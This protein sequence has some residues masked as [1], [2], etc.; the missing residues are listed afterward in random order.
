MAVFFQS[1]SSTNGF[2]SLFEKK[3]DPNEQ[4][5]ELITL[6]G[7][8][9]R[10]RGIVCDVLKGKRIEVEAF[11]RRQKLYHAILNGMIQKKAV[12]ELPE[13]KEQLQTCSF[14]SNSPVQTHVKS[15]IR[16]TGFTL[17][18]IKRLSRY[19]GLSECLNWKSQQHAQGDLPTELY[20]VLT[21]PYSSETCPSEA[22]L[23]HLFSTAGL[24]T[25]NGPVFWGELI[26]EWKTLFPEVEEIGDAF[27]KKH[28][29]AQIILYKKGFLPT[30]PVTLPKGKELPRRLPLSKLRETCVFHHFVSLRTIEALEWTLGGPHFPDNIRHH[31][32]TTFTLHENVR[33]D[34]SFA[35]SFPERLL[36]NPLPSSGKVVEILAFLRTLLNFNLGH[37]PKDHRRDD[38]MQQLYSWVYETNEE[39]VRGLLSHEYPFALQ[40]F[41][42]KDG[43]PM[44]RPC[45]PQQLVQSVSSLRPLYASDEEFNENALALVATHLLLDRTEAAFEFVLKVNKHPC[46]RIHTKHI[47]DYI[48]EK[49]HLESFEE[50]EQFF[51]F[52]AENLPLNL[53]GPSEDFFVLLIKPYQTS[54]EERKK[55]VLDFLMLINGQGSIN[56]DHFFRALHLHLR[57][58][59]SPSIQQVFA[60]FEKT[61][62]P[63]LSPN[64]KLFLFLQK[65]SPSP[66]KICSQFIQTVVV[67][68]LQSLP[69]NFEKTHRL[70]LFYEL[71][72][73]QNR[74][75][76]LSQNILFIR[77]LE[78]F[79]GMKLSPEVAYQLLAAHP[80]LSKKNVE[81]MFQKLTE[82]RLRILN[83][84]L[85][86]VMIS[87]GVIEQVNETLGTLTSS[88]GMQDSYLSEG[89]SITQFVLSSAMLFSRSVHHTRCF[90][91]GVSADDT[92]EFPKTAAPHA[93]LPLHSVETMKS[94][95][96]YWSQTELGLTYHFSIVH[97]ETLTTYSGS[98]HLPLPFQELKY[99][100]DLFQVL[101]ELCWEVFSDTEMN[102][103]PKDDEEITM[104]SD[105][106]PLYRRANI[107][108]L[109]YTSQELDK[110][111]VI[112]PAFFSFLRELKINS[113][114][115]MLFLSTRG[116]FHTPAFKDEKVLQQAGAA[117]H[118]RPVT[119]EN[120]ET[121]TVLPANLAGPSSPYFSFYTVVE[122]V[123]PLVDL[124]NEHVVHGGK[125]LDVHPLKLF[126]TLT[127][128]NQT[129]VSPALQVFVT[130]KHETIDHRDP[131]YDKLHEDTC[132]FFLQGYKLTLH[133]QY[134]LEFVETTLTLSQEEFRNPQRATQCMQY[135]VARLKSTFY[136]KFFIEKELTVDLEKILEDLE[137]LCS[138]LSPL[139]TEEN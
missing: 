91:S 8:D 30:Q 3:I 106:L 70:H 20:R 105:L 59:L 123:S 138:S 47:L 112:A 46:I 32:M 45:R 83:Q 38:A 76:I 25:P 81:G 49:G 39:N 58:K 104:L 79:L 73:L 33:M 67:P 34:V 74:P 84:E 16:L 71:I 117:M 75:H 82:L 85:E 64:E 113:R 128:H 35:I 96:G 87:S 115:A 63:T 24:F 107:L 120:Q 99:E 1:R 10:H 124:I 102:E 53:S 2:F 133:L 31:L 93:L 139:V 101:K 50:D 88:E 54:L 97:T 92:L 56:S 17:Y 66:E 43:S 68:N 12:E 131:K 19:Y 125:E 103:V 42:K 51:A 135:L 80:D 4:A 36:K 52:L 65:L 41:E 108:W 6:F 134:N 114:K 57:G 9:V 109:E 62:R 72:T 13:V 77:T 127:V 118:I 5:I 7:S 136:R 69:Y 122:D 78:T 110:N 111:G 98:A 126:L 137:A 86:K 90:P 14:S 26:L 100:T 119:F 132:R 11:N 21:I 129:A 48:T 28:P 40:E 22:A 37:V 44:L 27:L 23:T 29:H 60:Y 95:L 15:M 130:C 18:D 61:Y 94:S 89:A 121:F 116:Q 55:Q